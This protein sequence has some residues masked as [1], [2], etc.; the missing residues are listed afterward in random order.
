M[1]VKIMVIIKSLATV[2]WWSKSQLKPIAAM[3]TKKGSMKKARCRFGLSSRVKQAGSG[4]RAK[5]R[6]KI[7]FLFVLMIIKR[8][9]RKQRKMG[10]ETIPTPAVV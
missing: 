6:S 2:L 9:R 8:P 3:M 7:L 4:A 5:K 10:M 1:K